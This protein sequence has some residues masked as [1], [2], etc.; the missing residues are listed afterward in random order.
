MVN[1]TT[2]PPGVTSGQATMN[3]TPTPALRPA[4]RYTPVTPHVQV[5]GGSS[6]I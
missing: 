5:G 2:S 3:G 4:A 1:E 6:I